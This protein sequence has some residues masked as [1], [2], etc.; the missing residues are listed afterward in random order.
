MDDKFKFRKSIRLHLLPLNPDSPHVIKKMWVVFD[1]PELGRDKIY[2]ELLDGEETRIHAILNS[3]PETAKE[4]A[5]LCLPLIFQ[6]YK[7]PDSHV[8]DPFWRVLVGDL[9][10]YLSKNQ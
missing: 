5:E 10:V 1:H 7:Y 4:M 9:S 8:V 6:E 2:L 3:I